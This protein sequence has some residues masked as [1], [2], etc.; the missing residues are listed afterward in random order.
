MRSPRFAR[1]TL[2]AALSASLI[3]CTV[4]AS[5][6]A[7]ADTAL[8]LA[9]DVRG[10]QQPVSN[11]SIRLYAVGSSGDG[12]S[13][14]SLLFKPVLTDASG[15]FDI[16]GLYSCPPAPAQVYLVAAGG[17]PGLSSD[18]DNNALAMMA[19][20]GP[21]G[22]LSS[23]TRITVNELTTVGSLA[24]LYP[25]A[26]APDAIGSG[27]SDAAA[28]TN[29]FTTVTEYTNVAAGTVP[30]P[31][32][33]AGFYASGTEI[34]TLADIVAACVNSS[35]STASGTTCG[36]LFLY[37]KPSG[38]PA[39]TDTI[40]AVIDILKNPTSNVAAIFSLVP[41]TGSPFQPTLTAPP[42]DWTLPV[43]PIPTA[44]TFSI[45]AGSY[46]GT[47]TLTLGDTTSGAS[48]YYT[49]DGTA[50]TTSSSLYSG[51]LSLTASTTVKAMATVGGRTFSPVA[52]ASYLINSPIGSVSAAAGSN[53]T[54]TAGAAFAVPLQVRVLDNSGN[55]VSGATVTF[56]SPASAATFAPATCTT[57]SGGLCSVTATA[58]S[59][60]G[61]YTVSAS[62]AA[63]SAPFTLTNTGVHSFLVA[64]LVDFA[65]NDAACVDSATPGLAAN[66]QCTLRDA[67]GASAA[68]ATSAAPATI[69][70]PQTT[71][72]TMTLSHG[73]LNIPS[74]TTIQ[75]ATS[76]SGSTLANL[77]TINGT[78]FTIFTEAAGVKAATINNLSLTGGSTS[79]L[80]GA[81]FMSG[82][83]AVNQS[84][85]SANTSAVSG[86][87]ISNQGGVLTVD[88]STFVNN[89]AN[90]GFGGAIN[91]FSST[92]TVTVS[93]STFM[94]NSAGI[95]GGAIYS[96]G[97]ATITNSTIVG[98]TSPY[99]AGIYNKGTTM[100]V[101][102]SIVNGNT[103]QDCGGIL[104]LPQLGLCCLLLR[105]H[106][107]SRFQ[108]RHPCLHG[109]GREQ[110]LANRCLWPVHYAR[111]VCFDL[112]PVFRI[113][114]LRTGYRAHHRP[115][116]RESA[117]D[118]S[119]KRRHPQSL[120]H[121]QPGQF[122]RHRAEDLSLLA[123]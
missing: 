48:I 52:S 115:E 7:A 5:Q 35:G 106:A 120:Y 69:T 45:A 26:S 36:N 27:S 28:L 91:S 96:S 10:G 42:T 30:G 1:L 108:W 9:G 54:A 56:T 113:Q 88:G 103:N 47:Q 109:P 53:Q 15:N 46:V 14:V 12:S 17:N 112:R 123:F 71:A 41:S 73:T 59:S 38:S 121:H 101:T 65:E 49:I 85:F 29:A 6:N 67:L 74:Y 11:A 3:G 122:V 13:A 105:R 32:L 93:N 89:K 99:G 18:T 92:G 62:V 84:T 117:G 68:V 23:S 86:G 60:G 19:A 107:G 72:S 25:F 111:L 95:D 100:S 76:G 119:G 50:P 110:L 63:L 87:A 58:N 24:A 64:N 75:G 61:T 44:P 21:C 55:P 51:A 118:Y 102:N 16:T 2:F 114:P 79:S 70:F 98:N 82:T 8:H 116:L 94:G 77:I 40:T 31:G 43:L 78:G 33:P 90:T 80:G 39:P 66:A 97:T 57:N 22:S 83:L 81:I 104:L 4:P 37:A 34:I 20:L